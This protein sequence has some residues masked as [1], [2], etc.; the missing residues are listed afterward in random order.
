[1][2]KIVKPGLSH[3]NICKSILVSFILNSI[4]TYRTAQSNCNRRYFFFPQWG[5]W[6]TDMYIDFYGSQLFVE[7]NQSW[8]F[9]F[10]VPLLFSGMCY[11]YVLL[12]DYVLNISLKLI[13]KIHLSWITIVLYVGYIEEYSNE[14]SR[15]L[16]NGSWYI[17]IP[18]KPMK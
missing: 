4:I 16:G 3:S 10:L 17:C 11:I 5:N 18:N 9:G 13:S 14:S 7:K 8:S 6:I 12:T 15:L 2:F 1:M